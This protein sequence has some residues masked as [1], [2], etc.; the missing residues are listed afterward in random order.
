MNLKEFVKK[1]P[2]RKL[3]LLWFDANGEVQADYNYPNQFTEKAMS[4]MDMEVMETQTFDEED[5]IEVWL[6]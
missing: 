5:W 3:I 6:K 4:M 1:N 2:K